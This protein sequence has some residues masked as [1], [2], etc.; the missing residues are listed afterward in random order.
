VIFW[1]EIAQVCGKDLKNFLQEK[2]G[3]H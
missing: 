3:I 1:Q 2:Y